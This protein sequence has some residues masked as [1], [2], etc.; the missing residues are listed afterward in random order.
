MGIMWIKLWQEK[1][2][3]S[4]NLRA[5]NFTE[6]GLFLELLIRVRPDGPHLGKLCYPNGE[7][8]P[9][10]KLYSD[11]K[12]RPSLYFK[13]K[14]SLISKNVLAIDNGI[15]MLRKFEEL[16]SPVPNKHTT[17]TTTAQLQHNTSPKPMVNKELDTPTE[18]NRTD[19]D[20]EGGAEAPLAPVVKV[21]KPRKV[22]P[23]P[24]RPVSQ[25]DCLDLLGYF[26]NKYKD[27]VGYEYPANF[28]KDGKI[29]KDLLGL[30][31][32][33]EI[34]LNLINIFFET[35]SDDTGA[36]ENWVK[37]K[38]T[39]GVF[40]VKVPELLIKLREEQNDG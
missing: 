28:G 2:L 15:M 10:K 11:M 18:Q 17:N 29:L 32:K 5:C 21:E 31:R 8:I 20:K 33:P 39:I 3:S 23:I 6:H 36:K 4:M 12:L 25:Y 14:D 7:P 27:A 24:G 19:K 9:D 26:G 13:A 22:Y 30:Y 35:A 34:I 40:R 1:I 16:Q 38:M 37:G